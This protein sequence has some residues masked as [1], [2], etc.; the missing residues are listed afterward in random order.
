MKKS[1]KFEKIKETLKNVKQ[2]YS[3]SEKPQF[4]KIQFKREPLEIIREWDDVPDSLHTRYVQFFSLTFI[5]VAFA[6]ISIFVLRSIIVCAIWAL[7]AFAVYRYSL[8]LRD[9]FCSSRMA[10]LSGYVAE[11][12]RTNM[13]KVFN[14]TSVKIYDEDRQKEITVLIQNKHRFRQ[15]KNVQY[16]QGDYLIIYFDRNNAQELK[17][18]ELHNY[19]TIDRIPEMSKQFENETEDFDDFGDDEEEDI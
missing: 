19:F 7:A 5:S 9:L 8:F 17:R 13:N 1:S 4:H 14:T 16:L 15:S 2:Y 11:S 18:N 12:V 10:T 6:I 3:E